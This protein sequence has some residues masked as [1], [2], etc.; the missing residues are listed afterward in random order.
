MIN[1]NVSQINQNTRNINTSSGKAA[2]PP[3]LAT[4][5]A[6]QGRAPVSFEQGQIVRGEVIDIRN[7]EVTVKFGEE[8]IITARLQGQAELNIGEEASFRVVNNSPKNFLLEPLAKSLN[9]YQD[10]T[11]LKALE[12]ANLPRTDR[13][14]MIVKE[15]LNNQMSIDKQTITKLL[16]QSYLNKDVSVSTLVLM[17]KLHIPLTRENMQQFENYRNYE[18]RIMQEV[19]G[20][21][22]SVP[23]ILEGLSAGND[24]ELSAFHSDLLQFLTETKPFPEMPQIGSLYSSGELKELAYILESVSIP[25][26]IKNSILNG[27]ASLRDVNMVINNVLHT[28]EQMDQKML[29]NSPMEETISPDGNGDLSSAAENP[30]PQ[31]TLSQKLSKNPILQNILSQYAGYS[32]ECGELSS[33]LDEKQRSSL[34]TQL[35]DVP[36]PLQL[37]A[38]IADGSATVS[39]LLSNI[40]AYLPL[41]DEKSERSLSRSRE[42]H[43]LLKNHII[44][45]WSLTPNQLPKEDM[46]EFYAKMYKQ[47]SA[48]EQLTEHSFPGERTSAQSSALQENIDFMKT[49]NQIFPYVQLPI[50]LKDQNIH[51]DLYVYTNKQNL[52]KDSH[53]ISILLHLDMEYLGIMDIHIALSQKQVYSKFYLDTEESRQI[54]SFNIDRLKESVEKLGFTFL[55]EVHKRQKEVD[56]V[57]DFMEHDM[58]STSLKRYTFDIRA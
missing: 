53:N 51:S 24:A 6:M 39:E 29:L 57:K 11:I 9:Y 37:K 47:L 31:D 36:L 40:R 22:D 2:A 28:A 10:I 15:L 19:T 17:N 1:Q 20:L 30:L 7:N 25:E 4:P 5:D 13:N 18:H 12:E 42:Y 32:Y 46:G 41:T 44:R 8:T 45:S 56:V 21:A 52:Q 49:L 16:Q 14:F 55:A 58:P 38:A 43:A 3:K 50:K 48:F 23:E 34:L 26:D 54:I 35:K 33:L 27:S